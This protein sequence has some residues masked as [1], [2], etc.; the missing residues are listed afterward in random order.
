MTEDNVKCDSDNSG[1]SKNINSD[2]TESDNNE[3]ASKKKDKKDN[4]LPQYVL[5]SAR[6]YR[7]RH[8][9]KIK[10]YREKYKNEKIEVIKNIDIPIEK[11]TKNQIIAKYKVLESKYS[12]LVKNINGLQSHFATIKT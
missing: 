9:E 1:I 8:P 2:I 10:E 4:K 6:R 12:L 7:E 5:D 3:D 11:L